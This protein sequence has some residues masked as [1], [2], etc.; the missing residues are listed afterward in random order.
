MHALSAAGDESFVVA[1]LSYLAEEAEEIVEEA[2]PGE[3]EAFVRGWI[4]R[5]QELGFRE[6]YLIR[7]LCLFALWLGPAIEE[8]EARALLRDRE[9]SQEERVARLEDFI[10]GDRE[11]ASVGS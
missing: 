9:L 6:P 11:E 7:E 4:A 1:V 10:F 2:E 8:G 5:A 3:L